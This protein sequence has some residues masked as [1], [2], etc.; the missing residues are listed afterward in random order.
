[1]AKAHESWVEE[2][3]AGLK[4]TKKRALHELL[5]QLKTHALKQHSLEESEHFAKTRHTP[6]QHSQHV[7]RRAA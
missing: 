5:G 6:Q 3:F 2:L 1:M 7:S 4:L